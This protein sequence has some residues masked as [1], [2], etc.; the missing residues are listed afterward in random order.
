MEDWS[1]FRDISKALSNYVRYQRDAS[2]NPEED[3]A[4]V[5]EIWEFGR[6]QDHTI[7]DIL[8]VIS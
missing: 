5:I 2:K 8:H 4:S 1:S 3:M 7:Y 6:L